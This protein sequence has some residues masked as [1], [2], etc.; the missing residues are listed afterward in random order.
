[1][2]RYRLLAASVLAV[3]ALMFNA[4]L[5]IAQAKKPA[6]KAAT[7]KAAVLDINSA[8]KAELAALTGV[9]DT[10]SQKIIDGRPYTRKDQLVSKK[11]IPQT[12]YDQIK[13]QIIA[14]QVPKKK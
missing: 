3:V 6:T 9:G 8:S 7:T 10:Y 12:T 13:S 14:K 1:M 2:K 5:T 4:P 11:I